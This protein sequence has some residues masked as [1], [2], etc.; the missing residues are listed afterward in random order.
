LR[1]I[2][3]AYLVATSVNPLLGRQATGAGW[4]LKPAERPYL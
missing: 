4:H 3:P 2:D 1:K